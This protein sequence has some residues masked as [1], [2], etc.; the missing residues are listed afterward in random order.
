MNKKV[1]SGKFSVIKKSE[2]F[3]GV[4]KK[5]YISETNSY[6]YELITSGSSKNAANKKLKLIVTGYEMGYYDRYN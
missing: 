4:Y 3:Y 6:E 2:N 5:K 1:W